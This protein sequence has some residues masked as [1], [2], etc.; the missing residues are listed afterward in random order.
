MGDPLAVRVGP[1]KLK[2]APIG[3]AIPTTLVATWDVAWVDLGYTDAGST[4]VFDSTF[5]DVTVAEELDPI[6]TLQT[7]RRANVNFAAAELTA[8]HMQRAFNGGTVTTG[9]GIVTFTPPATGTYTP[10]M[11]AW[12]ASDVLERWVFKK[13]IQVGSVEIA[14]R[15]A[16]DKA[17][18]PMSFRVVVPDDASPI[19]AFIHDSN[20]TP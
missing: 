6:A 14:R 10:V 11:L 4:F 5:E 20:Y 9:T 13:C 2:I 7:A 17:T 8:A 15:K 18:L 19:F 1:G 12:E 16:P 3:T